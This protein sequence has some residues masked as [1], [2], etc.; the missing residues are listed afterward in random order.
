[1]GFLLACLDACIFC[2]LA[3]S[4]IILMVFDYWLV[5]GFFFIINT[6]L[7]VRFLSTTSLNYPLL[8]GMEL[9]TFVCN[10]IWYVQVTSCFVLKGELKQGLFHSSLECTYHAYKSDIWQL[11]GKYT[12]SSSELF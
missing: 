4:R 1:M 2:L 7:N 11:L 8:C 6:Y 12:L 5:L 9:F 3:C 10:E